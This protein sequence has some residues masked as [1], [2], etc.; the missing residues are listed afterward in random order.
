M[1]L[2]IPKWRAREVR[3]GNDMTTT[4]WAC[5][6]CKVVAALHW[7]PIHVVHPQHGDVI[8][9]DRHG[10]AMCLDCGARWHRAGNIA[11]IVGRYSETDRAR[12]EH[13]ARQL[14]AI[15]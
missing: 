13:A 6:K 11:M 1:T 4:A 5:D 2:V 9:F 12:V 10:H 7:R 14:L 15:C 8:L 3:D